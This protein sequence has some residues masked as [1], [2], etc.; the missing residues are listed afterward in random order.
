MITDIQPGQAGDNDSGVVTP[1]G[2]RMNSIP[3]EMTEYE[4]E[5]SLEATQAERA[6]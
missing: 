3:G 1:A 4:Y 2:M 5:A 6:R